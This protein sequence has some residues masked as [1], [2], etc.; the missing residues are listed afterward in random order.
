MYGEFTIERAKKDG[1]PVFLGAGT[2]GKTFAAYREKGFAGRNFREEV[3]LKVLNPA[4][5]QR[6]SNKLQF[7]EEITALSRFK[8]PNLIHIVDFGED[9]V[10]DR[11]E[12]YVAMELCK[13]GNLESLSSRYGRL[14]ERVVARIASQVCAG[15]WAVHD[16]YQMIHRD[17]KPSNIVLLEKVGDDWDIEQFARQLED[18]QDQCKIVD[19]GLVGSAF[20]NNGSRAGSRKF[21]GTPMYAS[22]EQVRRSALDGRTDIYALGMTMWFLVQGKGPLL[23]GLHELVDREQIDERILS[24]EPHTANFPPN[25]SPKFRDL[26]ARMV[27]KNPADRFSDARE[28]LNA[29]KE[30]EAASQERESDS[31]SYTFTPDTLQSIYT[32]GEEFGESGGHRQFYARQRS[33]GRDVVLTI[34]EDLT[35]GRVRQ[36]ITAVADHLSRQASLARPPAV[37]INIV[38]LTDVVLASDALAYASETPGLITLGE[39]LRL[40]GATSSTITFDETVVIF[41]P[42]AE[43]LDSLTNLGWE[44]ISLD[45]DEVWLRSEWDS[46]VGTWD[47]EKRRQMLGLPLTSWPGLYPAFSPA[48]P[49]PINESV[50]GSASSPY[51]SSIGDSGVYLTEAKPPVISFL[52]LLYATLS[53]AEIPDIAERHPHLYDPCIRLETGANN[54]I[55]DLLHKQED[56]T[57]LTLIFGELCRH[58]AVTPPLPTLRST[59]S[60]SGSSKPPTAQK[61]T[62][63]TPTEKGSEPVVSRSSYPTPP[64]TVR[65]TSPRS[66]PDLPPAEELVDAAKLCE[67]VSPGVVIGPDDPQRREQGVPPELWIGRGTV[68]C[69]YTG[70]LFRL[71]PSLP[72]LE[73]ISVEPLWVKSP[74]EPLKDPFELQSWSDWTPG[75]QIQCIHTGRKLILPASLHRPIAEVILGSPGQ[76]LTPFEDAP[77]TVEPEDWVDDQ[78]VAHG[79]TGWLFRLPSELPPLY[80]LADLETPGILR[81]P[82]APKSEGW[83]LA[84]DHWV[85]PGKTQCPVTGKILQLPTIVTSWEAVA[86]VADRSRRVVMNPYIPGAEV[87]VAGPQWKPNGSIPCQP[88]GRYLKLPHDLPPLLGIIPPARLPGQIQCP[89]TSVVTTIDLPN[90]RTGLLIQSELHEL[91]FELPE[92]LPL[93]LGIPCREFPGEIDS[94]Y[95]PG[96]TKARQK[97]DPARWRGDQRLKCPAT[98]LEFI[99]PH[100][101]PQLEAI[102]KPGQFGIAWSPFA[103]DAQVSILIDEWIPGTV[104]SCPKGLGSFVL[105]KN[106]EPW[107]VDGTWLPGRPG[108]IRSP[109]RGG[110]EQELEDSQWR[111]GT[112]LLCKKTGRYFSAP[113][114]SSFPTLGLEK[115]AVQHTQTFPDDDENAAS[116]ALKSA[117]PKATPKLIRSIW[118]RHLLHTPELRQQQLE[119]AELITDRPGWVKSPYP[120][121]TEVAIPAQ[122]WAEQNARFICPTTGRRFVLPPLSERPTLIATV[123]ND[124]AGFFQSPFDT[125]NEFHPVKPWEWKPSG[126]IVCPISSQPLVLPAPLPQLTPI[127][128]LVPDAFGKI[129]NPFEAREVVEDVPATKWSVGTVILF[130]NGQRAKLPEELPLWVVAGGKAI[131][132]RVESPFSPGDWIDVAPDD[133]QKSFEIVCPKTKQTFLLP[134]D[135]SPHPFEVTEPL[136]DGTALSPYGDKQRFQV[137]PTDWTDG[138]VLTYSFLA[139]PV[140]LGRGLPLLEGVIDAAH[141]LQVQ[142]PFSPTEWMQVEAKN[143]TD[144]QELRCARFNRPFRLPKGLPLPVVELVSGKPGYV[145]SPFEKGREIS[146]PAEKWE[147]NGSFSDGNR[148]LR[149]PADL[150]LLMG[151]I[152]KGKALLIRSPFAPDKD[153]SVPPLA[154]KAG[155]ELDCPSSKGRKFVLPEGLPTPS[156]VAVL[157]QPDGW[158][159]SPYDR[160]CRFLVAPQD[161]REGGQITCPK[162]AQPIVLPKRLPSLLAEIVPGE[163]GFLTSPY[164]PG[165]RI[166]VARRNWVAGRKVKCP[167]TGR[168]LLIPS[169]LPAFPEP[170][171]PP[172]PP[173]KEQSLPPKPQPKSSGLTSATASTRATQT[174][175]GQIPDIVEIEAETQDE[176]RKKSPRALIFGALAAAG[177]AA[178]AAFIYFKPAPPDPLNTAEL[179]WQADRSK[180]NGDLYH[181]LLLATAK[182]ES[183]PDRKT[184]LIQSLVRLGEETEKQHWGII[185]TDTLDLAALHLSTSKDT[186]GVAKILAIA[187]QS[188]NENLRRWKDQWELAQ[189]KAAKAPPEETVRFVMNRSKTKD[190]TLTPEEILAEIRP[191]LDELPEAYLFTELLPKLEQESS[192]AY[193]TVLTALTQSKL[194]NNRTKALLIH[195]QKK[196]KALGADSP[197]VRTA[198]LQAALKGPS[199]DAEKWL[200]KNVVATAD[201]TQPGTVAHP[202]FSEKH[203][204]IP[205]SLW[206]PLGEV[207]LNDAIFS[208][209]SALPPLLAQPPFTVPTPPADGQITNIQ[210]PLDAATGLPVPTP[211][212]DGQITNPYTDPPTT[213]PVPRNGWYR[214]AITHWTDPKTDMKLQIKLPQSD[215]FPL[216]DLGAGEIVQSQTQAGTGTAQVTSPITGKRINVP[217]ASWIPGA[218]LEESVS[219]GQP[220]IKIATLAKGSPPED[221]D[222]KFKVSPEQVSVE[223]TAQDG[224]PSRPPQ[225]RLTFI[226]PYTNALQTLPLNDWRSERA[227]DD[228]TVVVPDGKPRPKLTC[229]L[230][231]DLPA[232]LGTLLE[233]TSTFQYWIA[234]EEEGRKIELAGR[235]PDK[236]DGVT[237]FSDEN[238]V[239]FQILSPL[240]FFVEEKNW[241]AKDPRTGAVLDKAAAEKIAIEVA[242]L[243]LQDSVTLSRDFRDVAEGKRPG[244]LTLR[245]QEQKM[246]AQKQEDSKKMDAQKQAEA[247]KQA[248]SKKMEAQKQAEAQKQEDSKKRD[249][250]PPDTGK[251]KP[252]PSDNPGGSGKRGDAPATIVAR[253]GFPSW[254][255][256]W[257]DSAKGWVSDRQLRAQFK[258][259]KDRDSDIQSWIKASNFPKGSGY[260]INSEGKVVVTPP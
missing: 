54:L 207:R 152:V 83:D 245:E 57:T 246:E 10:G 157:D 202:F 82:Y 222:P 235:S 84:P 218:I 4:N 6:P 115:A 22:P 196:E 97:V 103:P 102:T 30:Y 162:T 12:T 166:E 144:G 231:K 177:V 68:I 116:K 39:V 24:P 190:G 113:I 201:E 210:A 154:W 145:W 242:K 70:R 110:I 120:P 47:E 11:V 52:R 29:L 251:Q 211:S 147:G 220:A 33:T 172:P 208:L 114:D 81:S 86:S 28:A 23:D 143:W 19:F 109:F 248:D 64:V 1:S 36:D 20:N 241:Q 256:G 159:I 121:R 193:D 104:I 137:Q 257:K 184:A 26:L 105:P 101:L 174:V 32:L 225:S 253:G 73:A 74:Y 90:W 78:L 213:L 247:Q 43:A 5:L 119:V 171:Q 214:G 165:P 150:P 112:L 186:E 2:F 8:H 187:G 233:G 206:R 131:A 126:P 170:A 123:S 111:P 34:I 134:P 25:L 93:P 236:F 3:A 45:I 146:V 197:E 217:W 88:T 124:K 243:N 163:P 192:Q 133:W 77:F 50:A 181:K 209:P 38:P 232:I 37:P 182:V 216:L 71:P 156:L 72:P 142:S 100:S 138:A 161:W 237:K 62:D 180:D 239:L 60:Q 59:A 108:W 18:R 41:H 63:P 224:D 56:W 58:Q 226:N 27:A 132:G 223:P 254:H 173:P 195:A 130:G 69:A 98:G 46:E 252:G 230:P 258:S 128:R 48:W 135:L 31:V 122:V 14:P 240:K 61:R 15:L 51:G 259:E 238:G 229:I 228:L 107:I 99:L 148:H 175:G 164:P 44:K 189:H 203:L 7:V 106:L 16:R 179:R 185:D 169:D 91:P 151:I 153:I 139:G 17:I 96:N 95:A 255:F 212:A 49:P 227:I 89:Y 158:I 183:Q 141:P 178:V 219:P 168:E 66:Q 92:G 13:G 176:G 94:P 205:G 155:H 35:M 199:P 125:S 198:Y 234:G 79:P 167:E 194:D 244:T 188:E 40:R 55:R 215:A 191:L 250:P 80:A 65:R 87:I 85:F 129:Y 160:L 42:I 260:Y 117:H 75:R 140:K 221:I 200:F 53:G 118:E 204:T 127:A 149:L 9:T 136:P 67:V 76:V 249:A 21:M